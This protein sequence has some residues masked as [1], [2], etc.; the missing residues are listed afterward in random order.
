M[1]CKYARMCK[2]YDAEHPTCQSDNAE[3]GHCGTYRIF[4]RDESE[5]LAL[6]VK[7][8]V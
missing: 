3:G 4:A 7:E 2:H 1:V 8:R 5:S 6:A